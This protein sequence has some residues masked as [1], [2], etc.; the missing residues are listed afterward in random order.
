MHGIQNIEINTGVG[1]V[2]TASTA[3]VGFVAT[4][5]AADNAAFPMDTPVLVTDIDAAIAK[6][7][8]T[9]TLKATLEAI[10]SQSS[11]V[12]VIVRVAPGANAG[13]QATNVAA[14]VVILS[15][16]PQ[17]IGIRPRLIGAP[18]LDVI[19]VRAALA[20]AAGKSKL[21]GMAYC[22]SIGA[23]VAAKVLDR[24]T[25]A[26]REVTLIAGNF[27]SGAT[28]IQATAVALG[29]RAR[30]DMEQGPQKSLSNVPVEGMTGLSD[31]ITF[32]LVDASTDAGVLNDAD[33]VC[34]V[35]LRGFRFWGNRTASTDDL[36]AFEPTVRVGQL[37]R[38][39]ISA[40]VVKFMDKPMHAS[41]AKDLVEYVNGE[42][43]RYTSAG[44]LLGGRAWLDASVNNAEGL[45]TGK[46]SV[47]YD[48]T[49]PPPLENLQ[50]RQRITDRY[51][52]DFVAVASA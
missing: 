39:T 18:G 12:L 33:I 27:K 32:D 31:A 48:Y 21:D 34:L 3:I 35:S 30:I 23:D 44:V 20:V 4:G 10:R 11:P 26:A 40:A 1:A 29:L 15:Q 47:D 45:R 49:V 24:A 13:E 16:A 52:T 37:I 51:L 42:L 25:V 6:A 2:Q 50:L 14:G 46:L 5:P 43:A 17:R 36:F 9:G 7:G 28:T 38:D 8:A 41:L 19:T 22:A